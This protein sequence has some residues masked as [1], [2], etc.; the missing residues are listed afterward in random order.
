MR[1]MP[2]R[3]PL[4]VAVW[5]TGNVGRPAIRA[6]VAHPRLELAAVVVADPAKV[7]CDAGELAHTAPTGVTA[8]PDPSTVLGSVDAIIYTATADTRPAEATADLVACLKS[9]AN[10]VSPSFYQL[11]HPPS[12]PDWLAGPVGE[13]CTAGNTSLFVSGIDPGWAIDTAAA[14]VATVVAGATEIRCQELF[15]YTLY[16]QPDVVRNVIGFGRP[17]DELPVMLHDGSLR[18]VW[19]PSLR[20]LADQLG[21]TVDDVTTAVERR[22][23]DTD[24]HHRTMGTFIAGTQGAF[25]FTVS[26]STVTAAGDPGPDLVVEHV[27]RIDQTCAPDW[28]QPTSPG[29]EHRV[30]VTG[31][32]DVT[33]T[34]HGHEPTEPGAAGGGNAVAANRLVNAI[35]AVCAAPPGILGPGDL[36]ADLS[37][38]Y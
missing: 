6:V 21:L 7:G 12:A 14:A 37:A 17:L 36:P 10:V 15:D 31:H 30:A 20:N 18:Y 2:S 33:V 3:A 13:A 4:R 19:E 27:T 26:A 9:G 25:R 23:L 5:G 8:T 29:G 11:A 28:P 32:P 22:R 24:M 38:P 34:I 16:D 1:A 35:P